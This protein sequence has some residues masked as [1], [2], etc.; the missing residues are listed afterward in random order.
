MDI[1]GPLPPVHG[2]DERFIVLVINY[3]IKWEEAETFTNVTDL[4]VRNFV[5]KHILF[6]FGV[7]NEIVT[8]NGLQFI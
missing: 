1:I 5:W 7:P 2:K 8:K 6:Q 3:Y 4:A